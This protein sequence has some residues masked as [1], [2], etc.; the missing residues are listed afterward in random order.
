MQAAAAEHAEVKNDEWL[1]PLLASHNFMRDSE[2]QAV[3]A[4]ISLIGAL[5]TPGP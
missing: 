1:E 3:L 4:V 5:T 2:R